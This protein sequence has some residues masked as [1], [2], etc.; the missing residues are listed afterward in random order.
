MR[1]KRPPCSLALFSP[2]LVPLPSLLVPLATLSMPVLFPKFTTEGFVS[3]AVPSPQPP[4]R[5]PGL[6]STS[7]LLLWQLSFISL[8]FY[9]FYKPLTPPSPQPLA[10][11]SQNAPG[12]ETLAAH[13][14]S[15]APLVSPT[16]PHPNSTPTCYST[17]PSDS[18]SS[19]ILASSIPFPFQFPF[20]LLENPDRM[21]L[22]RA[23]RKAATS[24]LVDCG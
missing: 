23:Y 1:L 21:A 8:T 16:S 11:I 5:P 10:P 24:I 4:T 9:R 17:H 13:L 12:S 22:T 19:Q 3:S 6:V 18:F 20:Q 7:L 2:L 15:C 14:C